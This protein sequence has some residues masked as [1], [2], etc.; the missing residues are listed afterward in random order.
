MAYLQ[1]WDEHVVSFN[2]RASKQCGGAA[3]SSKLWLE[4]A[5]HEAFARSAKQILGLVVGLTF[6]LMMVSMRSIELSVYALLTQ[7]GVLS[8][9]A[10]FLLVVCG[11]PVGQLEITALLL[12]LGGAMGNGVH[13][14]QL[15]SAGPAPSQPQPSEARK[16][17]LEAEGM[18]AIRLSR[19]A[20]AVKAVGPAALF[21][22]LTRLS[23]GILLASC[24][25]RLYQEVA[26]A[27]GLV[28]VLSSL[29]ILVPLPAA[30]LMAGPL[31]PGKLVWP[32]ADGLAWLKTFC[33]GGRR[34]KRA[35]GEAAGGF[36]S[37]AE[38]QST[39][40]Q[41]SMLIPSP[42]PSSEGPPRSAHIGIEA[43][44]TSPKFE[45]AARDYIVTPRSPRGHFGGNV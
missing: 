43:S 41:S 39:A 5:T 16:L 1:R 28:A 20:F 40:P 31:Q 30:L 32:V 15:Y 22:A 19:V 26:L 8:A 37:D 14:L 13:L 36:A 38:T 33:L 6:L 9:L 44:P 10:F 4:A 24:S 12:S 7:A 35:P 27:S 2:E 34:L 25:L 17:E 11:W 29:A 23:C 18:L 42:R 21:S 3:H 45:A